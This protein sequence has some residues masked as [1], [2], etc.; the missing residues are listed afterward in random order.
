MNTL[1]DSVTSIVASCEVLCSGLASR[2]TSW[3]ANKN[4]IPHTQRQ[5]DH[6]A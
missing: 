1:T 6:H 5:G 3:H 2:T 4:D